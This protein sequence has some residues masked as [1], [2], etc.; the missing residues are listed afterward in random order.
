MR[1]RYDV[2]VVGARVAGSTL[3]ALLGDS[4]ASVLLLDRARF[5]STTPSTHFF[6]GAGMVSVLSR[7]GVLDDVLALGCPPLAREFNYGDGGSEAVEGPPQE[8]GEVGFCLW[9]GGSRST[10]SCCGGAARPPRCSSARGSATCC[11]TRIAWRGCRS[12]TVAACAPRWWSAPTAAT[13][14]SPSASGRGGARRAAYRALYYRYVTGFAGPDGGAARRRRVLTARRRDRL[15]LPERRR[16]HL[17]R[18][19]RQPRD[20]PLAPAATSRLATTSGS[21]ATPAS[22]GG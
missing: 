14:W 3:A 20:V 15:R 21:R 4:G 13:P 6:R 8:P 9:S 16:P 19:L 1:D 18:D 11:G 2:I 22:R 7:L 17:R 5:P 12:P 10:R